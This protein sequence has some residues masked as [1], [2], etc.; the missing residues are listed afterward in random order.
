V[1]DA[2]QAVDG[3]V[4]GEAGDQLNVVAGSRAPHFFIFIFGLL[5]NR[6]LSLLSLSLSLKTKKRKRVDGGRE[7]GMRALER[8]GVI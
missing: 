2:G 3:H 5:R 8:R 1:R 7:T 6:S 4:V